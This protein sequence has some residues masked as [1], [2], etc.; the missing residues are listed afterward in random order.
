MLRIQIGQLGHL[1]LGPNINFPSESCKHYGSLTELRT[2][3]I[4][5]ST[6]TS[7][8]PT[9]ARRCVLRI[10]SL[11]IDAV[12]LGDAG[13]SAG[14]ALADGAK[15][16]FVATAVELAEDHGGFGG[17]IFSEIEACQF[18]SGG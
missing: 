9:A 6:D 1:G 13:Q 8:V 18:G 4:D 11:D 12:V 3:G 2:L 15:F 14:I 10:G 5:R 17:R 7:P 16:P